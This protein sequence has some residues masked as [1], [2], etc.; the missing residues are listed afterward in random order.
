MRRGVLA[1]AAVLLTAAVAGTLVLTDGFGRRR[2][3]AGAAAEPPP[4]TA[5]VTRQTLVDTAAVDGDLGYG[6]PNPAVNRLP[7]TVTWLPEPG[8]VVARGHRLYTVD[9]LPVVLMYGAVPAFRPLAP[10]AE[11]ADVRQL[12]QNL[13]A[14]G[15][16]GFTV[17]DQYTSDTADAVRNWQQDLGLPETGTVEL[18][19]VLFTPAAARVDS[20]AVAVGAPAAPGPVLK[21]TGTARTVLATLD[22]ADQRLARRGAKVGVRLPDGR[23]VGGT[24]TEVDTVIEPGDG[25]NSDP[26]TR[27]EAQVALADQKAVRGLDRAAVKVTFTAARRVDVLTVPVAALVALAEGGYG[28]AVVTGPTT[29]YLPVRTGLFADGR[30]EISGAGLTAGTA[31]GMP[32]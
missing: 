24:V 17:D 13:H 9:N 30:V 27:I 12:E 11:G 10:G 3:D 2:G 29:R 7:G 21:Y 19:R 16:P 15:Y 26:T 14:L 20:L 25:Q 31:V 4:S 18:G 6:V 28:V 32:R 1:G 22:L 5:P 23:S 8:T